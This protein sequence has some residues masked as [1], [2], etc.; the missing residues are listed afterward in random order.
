[1]LLLFIT[2]NLV[3]YNVNGIRAVIAKGFLDW[4]KEGNHDIVCLQE[5]KATPD[6]F[7]VTAFTDLGYNCYWHP[8]QKRGYSGTAILSKMEPNHTA[9]GIS[10]PLFDDEGRV[11][12][13]DYG[14]VTLLCVYFPSGTTGDIRQ[15][16]KME[17]LDTITNYVEELRKERPKLILAGDFNICHKPIDINNPQKHEKVSGFLPEERAWFDRFVELGWTDT[18]RVF[19]QDPGRYSWW[20]YRSRAKPKNLGWRIDYF[21][22]TDNLKAQLKGA[23]ILDAISFSD[24]CPITLNLD[25]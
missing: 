14:D 18:F 11:I 13:A 7:D 19:C 15:A 10:V 20:S 4:L 8:A 25:F 2:V 12:R 17:F 9:H 1:M 16:I 21:M 23:D 3:S 22:V 6:Q 24:H 5:I